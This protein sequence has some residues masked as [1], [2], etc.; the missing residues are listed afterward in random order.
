MDF[1]KTDFSQ[2]NL[3]KSERKI[4]RDCTQKIEQSKNIFPD[5]KI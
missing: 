3:Q 5:F 1:F 4:C 2:K